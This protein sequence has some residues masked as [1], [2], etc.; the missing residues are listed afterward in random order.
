[1]NTIESKI[2]TAT[3]DTATDAAAGSQKKDKKSYQVRSTYD[4]GKYLTSVAYA[5]LPNEIR[6]TGELSGTSAEFYS[7]QLLAKINDKLITYGRFVRFENSKNAT[8]NSTYVLGSAGKPSTLYQIGF[9]YT[10]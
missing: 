4:T 7:A 9:E 2:R 3:T 5:T 8:Y 10:W 6:D 1:M